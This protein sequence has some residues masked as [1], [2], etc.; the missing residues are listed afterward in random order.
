MAKITNGFTSIE[1]V[2]GE[3]LNQ[4][5][6]SGNTQQITTDGRSFEDILRSISEEN[7]TEPL[8]F[9]K[10]AAERLD[11]RQIDLSADQMNRLTT[12]A[13]MAGEKGIKDSLIM[14]DSLAFIVNI[15]NNTVVTAMDQESNDQNVFTN[16]DGAVVI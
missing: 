3:F 13:Q 8:K 1:Q 6:R 10:H 9:S 2:T 16:I 14:V 7:V 5:S 11:E 12:G 4:T 15:P